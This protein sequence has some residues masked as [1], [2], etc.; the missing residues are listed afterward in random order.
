MWNTE[1]SELDTI[2]YYFF[3]F[4]KHATEWHINK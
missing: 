2:Y 4:K 1:M 3:L